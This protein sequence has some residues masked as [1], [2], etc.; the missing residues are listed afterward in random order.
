MYTINE[1]ANICDISVY[2]IRFYD[3]EGLLPFVTRN[4]TGNRQ[5]NEGDLDIIKLICCLKNTGMQIKEIKQYI[6]LCMQGEGT[7]TKRRQMMADH[8]KAILRQIDDLKK[9]LNIVDLKIGF[10]D[11]YLANPQAGFD[12]LAYQSEHRE[13]PTAT[14]K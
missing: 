2:T 11:S 12:P 3:K 10:Y 13:K 7:A 5:F 4:S 1:V 9:N 6:D 14:S 8:R